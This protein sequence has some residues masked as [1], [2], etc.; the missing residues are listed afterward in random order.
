MYYR[1]GGR[2]PELV[3]RACERQLSLQARGRDLLAR[4]LLRAI[5]CGPH[6]RQACESALFWTHFQAPSLLP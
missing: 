6:K 4:L 2:V 1:G 3:A 5:V